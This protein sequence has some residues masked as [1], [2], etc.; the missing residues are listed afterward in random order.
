MTLIRMVKTAI[1]LALA[2]V[3]KTANVRVFK[4]QAEGRS[5]N[6]PLRLFGIFPSKTG[7]TLTSMEV[8]IALRQGRILMAVR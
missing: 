3:F 7:I 4:P 6:P 5:I 1:P 2:T 8:L